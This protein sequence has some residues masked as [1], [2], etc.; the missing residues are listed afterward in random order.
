MANSK[1]HYNVS[2][3]EE[4]MLDKLTERVGMNRTAVVK[5]G[6]RKCFNEFIA[7]KHVT[8]PSV[9]SSKILEEAAR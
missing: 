1:I 3:E 2:K 8:I 7:N 9:D 5:A 4:A 6:L